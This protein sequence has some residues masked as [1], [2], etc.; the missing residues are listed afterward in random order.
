MASFHALVFVALALVSAAPMAVVAGDP[1]ILTDFVVPTNLL[2]VPMNV[3]ADFF[4]YTGF[5]FPFLPPA[6]FSVMK[7]SMKEF[8]ALEGQSVSYAKLRFPP[9]TVNPTHTHPRAA[10]LL[11]V[12]EGALSVG[13]VDT[14]GKLYTKDLVVGDMFVFPKG[15]VHY[16]YNQ[17]A[18]LAVALSAFGSANAGTVSVPLTVFGTGV[19]DVVLAKSFKTDVA[20]VQKLK[21]A[22][23]P[24]PSPK[25]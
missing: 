9:G 10:E 4:T 11:L 14:A 5:A 20:T 21:A 8:P 12:L 24:P 7:A 25:N 19:D 6:T 18:G 3:T 13:F 2:G 22:L 23:T 17:G 15:L 16:Q 1:D